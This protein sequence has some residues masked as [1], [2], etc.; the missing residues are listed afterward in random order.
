MLLLLIF[1][2]Y[3]VK[4]KNS[5]LTKNALHF[6]VLHL[7]QKKVSIFC[8]KIQTKKVNK[9]SKTTIE[10][11]LT[12]IVFEKKK[13]LTKKAW[14]KNKKCIFVKLFLFPFFFFKYY[15]CFSFFCQAFFVRHFL[16]GL[17]FFVLLRK[18]K[19]NKKKKHR[20]LLEKPYV[21]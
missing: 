15:F 17:N 3:A 2:F 14:D 11:S 6:F 9:K 1:L 7:K 16:S 4:Q 19:K 5:N 13:G 10:K 20:V 21:F 12:K 8:F 18:T